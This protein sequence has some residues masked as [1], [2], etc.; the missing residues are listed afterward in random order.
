M[1]VLLI[2]PNTETLPDPVFPL[3]L[4]YIAA[5]LKKA[6]IPYRVVDLC[7]SEDYENEIVSAIEDFAPDVVGLSLRNFDNV[8]YPNYVT[9]LPLFRQIVQV[10][11]GH[12]DCAIVLGGS[13]FSLMPAEITAYLAADFGIAGEGEISFIRLLHHLAGRK[14]LSDLTASK[15]ITPPAGWAEDLDDISPPDRSSFDNQAYLRLGG[16]GNIQTKRGC[17]FRCIYCTYP[18]IEGK[19]TRLRNPKRICDEIVQLL[20]QG[21]RNV[22]I[23]DNEFNHP[24]DHAM[25]VCREIIRRKLR[26]KWSCYANPGFITRSFV[27]MMLEAGCTGLEFGTDAASDTM[28]K[29]LSKN[30]TVGDLDEASKICRNAEMSFCHSLLLGGPGETMT[31][32][33]ETFDAVLETSPTAVICMVGIR[34]FPDT[35]LSKIAKKEGRIKP[36]QDFLEPMFYLS[37]AVADEIVPFIEA[38]A[39]SHPTWIFPGL[40]INMD[41]RLQKKLRRF[42][43][44]G[45]L[46]E[47]MRL[48]Q[49]FNPTQ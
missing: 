10:I 13:G 43:I 39:K 25:A 48:G 33:R 15:V 31:S 28:L 8:S 3:G 17:P 18:I 44:K 45:P 20:D 14:D 36:G 9:Y 34:I 46:W 1:N 11:R 49:K 30:F 19:R 21:I 12:S 5:A 4:A 22:F 38:F 32:V 42:G 27:D 35:E 29:N 24:L 40:N 41:K 47:H 23:V 16:M 37:E 6:A 7:F 2:S 26:I